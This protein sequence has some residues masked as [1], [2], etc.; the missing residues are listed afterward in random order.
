MCRFR[1]E[2]VSCSSPNPCKHTLDVES[3]QCLEPPRWGML[4]CIVIN[5]VYRAML[6]FLWRR[7]TADGS[8]WPRVLA[9][10][11]TCCGPGYGTGEGQPESPSGSSARLSPCPK[12]SN[13]TP[14]SL[15]VPWYLLP[16]RTCWGTQ[17]HPRASRLWRW[18]RS[19]KQKS[20]ERSDPV[21]L[22]VSS[23]K[24]T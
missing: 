7:G 12:C 16:S 11:V 20:S 5:A 4:W 6:V 3:A 8:A 15:N 14:P 10:T 18:T 17:K 9:V 21:F 23:I 19:L 13:W 1:A 2:E 22:L 24:C